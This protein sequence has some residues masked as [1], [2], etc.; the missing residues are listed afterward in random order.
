M[1]ETKHTINLLLLKIRVIVHYNL[2]F[3]DSIIFHLLAPEFY[4]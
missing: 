2:I 4:V 1:D 3:R